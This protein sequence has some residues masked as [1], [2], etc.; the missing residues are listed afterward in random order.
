MSSTFSY[1]LLEQKQQMCIPRFNIRKILNGCTLSKQNK[2]YTRQ[3]FQCTKFSYL[4]NKQLHIKQNTY[5]TRHWFQCTKI[6]QLYIQCLAAQYTKHTTCCTRQLFQCTKFSYL[7][8][9]QLHIKQ[10]TYRTRHW[11]QCTKIFQL[12]IQCLAAQCT[13]HTTCCTRQY[14]GSSVPSSLICTINSYTSN[15]T[16]TVPGIGSSIPRYFNCTYNV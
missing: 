1:R 8:N 12:Y 9:K 13:K 2:Y 7:Y 16:P 6:F 4:Y 5:R 3:W 11:F 10:N 14:N 15:R